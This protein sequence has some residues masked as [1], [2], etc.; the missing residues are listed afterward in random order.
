MKSFRY[1]IGVIDSNHVTSP[2]KSSKDESLVPFE[3]QY[4]GMQV[5]SKI[6]LDIRKVYMIPISLLYVHRGR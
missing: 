3:V 6:A 4:V 5:F 1:T 2:Q